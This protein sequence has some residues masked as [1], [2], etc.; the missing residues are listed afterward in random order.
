MSGTEREE[1]NV[2]YAN[3]FTS[4]VAYSLIYMYT[5]HIISDRQSFG[6]RICFWLPFSIENIIGRCAVHVLCAWGRE[7]VCLC[8]LVL[9]MY[10]CLCVCVIFIV[11]VYYYNRSVFVRFNS[12]S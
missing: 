12:R 3:G 6:V 7:G 10:M 8:V 11:I 1:L 9:L 4:I 2:F 5:K